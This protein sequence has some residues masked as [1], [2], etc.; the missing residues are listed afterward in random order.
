VRTLAT[1]TKVAAGVAK[2]GEAVAGE[3][4]LLARARKFDSGAYA[5]SFKFIQSSTVGG[6]VKATDRKSR[7]MEFGT[8]VF[9]PTGRPVTAPGGGLMHFNI[10]GRHISV[11]SHRGQP[12]AHA[13]RDA[14]RIVSTRLGVRFRWFATR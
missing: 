10:D 1:S 9:G 3:G 8:G 4:Q 12:G 7:W 5:G 11:Y 14:G 13:M 6:S 2:V